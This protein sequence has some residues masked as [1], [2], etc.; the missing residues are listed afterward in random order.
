M[1]HRYKFRHRA[2]K[3]KIGRPKTSQTPIDIPR[4]RSIAVPLG[5]RK[6]G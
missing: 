4:L 2:R 1:E 5:N 6:K 3:P